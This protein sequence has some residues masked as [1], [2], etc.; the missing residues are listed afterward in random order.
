VEKTLKSKTKE[1]SK[2]G[3]HENPPS[4]LEILPFFGEKMDV[5]LAPRPQS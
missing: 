2:V 3:E 5:F 1:I 4:L